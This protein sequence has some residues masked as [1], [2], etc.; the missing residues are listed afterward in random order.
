MV[1]I[2]VAYIYGSCRKIKTEFSFIETPSRCTFWQ[3]QTCK[4]AL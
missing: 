1:K 4:T 2:G 3:I